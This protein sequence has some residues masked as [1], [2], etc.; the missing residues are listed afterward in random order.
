MIRTA[1]ESIEDGDVPL[2]DVRKE[3]HD[4]RQDDRYVRRASKGIL[5]TASAEIGCDTVGQWAQVTLHF[6]THATHSR[7]E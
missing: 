1:V 4:I 3:H 6:S 7:Y 2:G 5:M